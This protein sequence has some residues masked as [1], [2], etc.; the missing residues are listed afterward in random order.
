MDWIWYH[1]LSLI[2]GLISSC[3][4]G[5]NFSLAILEWIIESF[6]ALIEYGAGKLFELLAKFIP[7]V[8]FLIGIIG[9]WVISFILDRYFTLKTVT[10]ITN[11]FIA[12]VKNT[13]LVLGNWTGC[14]VKSL[15]A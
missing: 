11:K 6:I 12:S 3:K 1:F 2:L 9:G 13:P 7:Y 15:S 8:G 14:A 5:K 4:S 10:R